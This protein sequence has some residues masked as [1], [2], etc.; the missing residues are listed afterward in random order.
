MAAVGGSWSADGARTDRRP[1]RHSAGTRSDAS[2][3]SGC[4]A[5]SGSGSA[6][7]PGMGRRDL[8]RRA[9]KPAQVAAVGLD[10]KAESEGA[11]RSKEVA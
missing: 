2:S 11:S 6:A 3:G 1:N 5:R 7:A 8:R 10:D 4:D 9:G